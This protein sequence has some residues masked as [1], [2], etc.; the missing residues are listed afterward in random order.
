MAHSNKKIIMSRLGE[1]EI[2]LE[3][4]IHFPQGLV[5]YTDQH[6]FVLLEIKEGA[7]FLLLQS[8]NQPD[9]GFLVADP[10][11]FVSDYT[12]Q[13]DMRA[14]KTLKATS[15]KDLAVLVTVSIPPGKP[16]ETTLNLTGPILINHAE[17]LGLQVPQMEGQNPCRVHVHTVTATVETA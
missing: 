7:P 8:M 14:E 9:L 13:A 16:E 4:V 1:R 11:S 3:K 5:G 17:R 15:Q 6:D 12:I 10:F 2:S